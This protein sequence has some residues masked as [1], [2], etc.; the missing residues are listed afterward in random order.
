MKFTVN[1]ILYGA[2]DSG[3]VVFRDADTLGYQFINTGNCAV[4]I[5]NFLLLPDTVWKS[6]EA[7]MI[8]TTSYRINFQ[9]FNSCA[10]DNAELT[11]ILYQAN[12]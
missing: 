11:V 9:Q 5:N 2:A 3:S 12:K 8:D 4:W 10:T 6:F 7:G 1:T